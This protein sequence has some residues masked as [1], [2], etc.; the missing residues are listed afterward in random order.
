MVSFIPLLL[1]LLLVAAMTAAIWQFSC[2]R[3]RT[4]KNQ[5]VVYWPEERRRVLQ[6]EADNGFIVL[7]EF[8]I[9]WSERLLMVAWLAA[10]PTL[11]LGVQGAL[12]SILAIAI[13]HFIRS[14]VL[15]ALGDGR[16]RAFASL[17][18]YDNFGIYRRAADDWESLARAN[19][20]VVKFSAF[21]GIAAGLLLLT[22]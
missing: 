2:Y 1:L 22:D 7:V 6:L 9:H 12:G 18:S 15:V 20:K 21:V 8:L 17:W 14:A 19:A 4:L 5:L 11:L 10:I 3:W 13:V 16:R